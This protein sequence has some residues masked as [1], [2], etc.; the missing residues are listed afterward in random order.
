MANTW[1]KIGNL[2]G[3]KGD[4]GT[5]E[6]VARFDAIEAKNV[7]Q[8]TR[9]T[10]VESKNTTQ[11]GRLTTNESAIAALQSRGVLADGT[12]LNTLNGTAHVGTYGLL[13]TSTYPNAPAVTMTSTAVLE[14]QRGAGNA[15]VQR[16]TFG[17]VLLWREAVDTTAGTWSAWAQVQTTAAADAAA[18]TLAAAGPLTGASSTT[19]PDVSFSITDTA[20]RRSWLEVDAAGG[21]T[22]AAAAAIA[23]SL[24]AVESVTPSLVDDTAVYS[25]TDSKGRRSWLEVDANGGP[26]FHSVGLLKAAGLVTGA[27]VGAVAEADLEPG[28][29]ARIP[30]AFSVA[31]AKAGKTRVLTV[32][33]SAGLVRPLTSDPLQVS[34]WGDSLFDGYP[35]PPYNADQSNSVPGVFATLYPAATVYN[36]GKQGQS[37]DEIAI[38]QGGIVPM[39]TVAGGNI[40]ASGSV[41][42]TSP[43]VFAWRLDRSADSTTGTLAGVPGTLTF[44]RT[45]SPDM[46]FTRTTPGTAVPVAG[47]VPWESAGRAYAGGLQVIMAGRNDIGYNSPVGVPSVDRVV[48]ATVAMVESLT[49]M[50]RR[51]LLLG[52]TTSTAEITGSNGYNQVTAINAAL[53]S[54]YPQ[55][56]WDY[57]AWLVKEAIYELGITPTADDL[58]AMAGDTLPPSIMTDPVHYSPATAAKAAARIKLELT[59]RGWI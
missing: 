56:F 30:A 52:A 58:T 23:A 9:L 28:L 43:A 49:P 37:A 44:V 45:A 24:P 20:G 19:N 32:R 7:A 11:D 27:G 31:D 12:D 42:V 10:N 21:P 5:T 33:D 54:L 59:N 14:V 4:P 25:V 16:I 53:K 1:V 6:A 48:T 2:K 22:L 17:T 8:D 46:T 55:F 41:T 3:P 13:T 57:R 47:A 18:A 40:P 50:N 39:L 26:T 36:F 38:R 29:A 15:A 34:F 51:V 35:V